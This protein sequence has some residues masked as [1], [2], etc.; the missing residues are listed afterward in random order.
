MPQLLALLVV[1]ALVL[2]VTAIAAGR[3]AERGHQ[4][5][6]PLLIIWLG[7]I[8]SLYA[9]RPGL[10]VRSAAPALA[11]L[12]PLGVTALAANLEVA[13]GWS[14]RRAGSIAVLLGLAVAAAAPF[15]VSFV[16]WLLC[17]A[18]GCPRR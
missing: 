11:A 8:V 12:A 4:P 7:L 5:W 13:R 9:A 1:A 6:L 10:A 17:A 18:S 14:L 2:S 3:A 16:T 15:L